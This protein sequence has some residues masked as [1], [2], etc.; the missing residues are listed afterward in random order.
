VALTSQNQKRG[1][2]LL[3]RIL[4]PVALVVPIILIL[5]ICHYFLLLKPSGEG[6]CGGQKYGSPAPP[7]PHLSRFRGKVVGKNLWVV[8]YRW[9]RRLFVPAG[10]RLDL[11]RDLPSTI[12]QGNATH[13]DERVGH[14][15]VDR[16]G[17]F[18]FGDLK[19]GTYNLMVSYPG[20]DAVMFGF[21]IDASARSNNVLID[22]SP[23]YYCFCCGWNFEPR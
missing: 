11:V 16:T 10:T 2:T 23:A 15:I 19:P 22:A 17:S 7:L 12:Y 1:V 4:I 8:Q 14:V 18:D 21:I 3:Q 6:K 20:E 13:H 5:T 9:L